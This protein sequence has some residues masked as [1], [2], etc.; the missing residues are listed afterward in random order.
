[1]LR[2]YAYNT[3]IYTSYTFIV[4]VITQPHNVSG[5]MGGTVMLTC[6]MRFQ[7]VN[8]SKEDIEW[9]RRRID[10]NNNTEIIKPQGTTAFSITSNISGGTLTSVLMINSLRSQLIGPYWLE[11]ADGTQMSDVAFLSIVPSGM[12][13]YIH[14]C[15]LCMCVHIYTYVHGCSCVVGKYVTGFEITC[16]PRTQQEDTLFTIT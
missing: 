16:L 2:L 7:N 14:I 4:T 3:H 11:I 8:I 12:C 6:V 9:W 10:Q 15:I 13:M 5:C 1:M